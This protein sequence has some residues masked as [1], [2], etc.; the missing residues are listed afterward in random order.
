MASAT[1]PTVAPT[2]VPAP[3]ATPA[4]LPPT[5]TTPVPLSGA[6][7]F[8]GATRV[9]SVRVLDW[10]AQ[11]FTKV[12]GNV[13]V[14]TAEV[15][16]SCAVGGS[17][18][19]RQ[20]SLS[21]SHRIDGELRVS[22]TLRTRG[23]LRSGSAVSARNARLAGTVEI[24]GSLTV[25]EKL[26]WNGALEVSQNVRADTVLFQGQVT[27]HG[28][29]AARTIAGRVD[30]LS[31]V[32]EVEADWVEIRRRK[33]AL[34]FPIFLLPPPPWHDLEIHRIEANEVHLSGVRVRHLKADRIWLGPATHVE[35][36][37]GTI[38]ER[39]KEA[40]VGPESESPPPPGLSR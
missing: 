8:K 13:E 32:R 7:H 29:L 14:A 30:R 31:S 3:A 25:A 18:V 24:G 12:I 23:T 16:G 26:E 27:V 37:E 2:A 22:E 1:P 34:P 11:G 21:G 6:L 35:Y 38:V 39:H 5:A 10:T 40:H 28:T 17:F 15:T 4:A 19:A 20:L 33:P 9:P 36:V